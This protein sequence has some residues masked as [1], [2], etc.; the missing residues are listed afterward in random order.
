LTAVQASPGTGL[1]N[2]LA[3]VNTNFTS[4]FKV[5]DKDPDGTGGFL[6]P[7][8]SRDGNWLVT[9]H[10]IAQGGKSTG[11]FGVAGYLRVYSV[12]YPSGVITLGGTGISG[13]T[14]PITFASLSG[15][16]PTGN[17][18]CVLVASNGTTSSGAV[19][20]G[21]MP[22]VSGSFSGQK[23]RLIFA[24]N[25]YSTVPTTWTV[26]GTSCGTGTVTTTGGSLGGADFKVPDTSGDY[27]VEGAD[28]SADSQWAYFST[29]GATTKA[30][31]QYRLQ[32]T[33]TFPA[34]TITLASPGGEEWSEASR[35]SPSGDLQC[36]TSSRFTGFEPPDSIGPVNLD[37]ACQSIDGANV[38][39]ITFFN[40]VTNSTWHIASANPIET[41]VFSFAPKGNGIIADVTD[42]IFDGLFWIPLQYPKIT[43]FGNVQSFGQ[44]TQH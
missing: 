16:S 1:D 14:S 5:L 7:R 23:L 13:F 28:F 10:H 42:G 3:A 20:Y 37:L 31:H 29:I 19:A 22:S 18:T 8:I 12:T 26:S 38:W 35:I 9:G 33:A 27:F 24:G 21:V 32:V 30:V 40:Q 25:G 36:Y 15:G 2:Y 6:Q 41:Q 39:P 44:V 11:V 4:G 43:T 34:T 17:Q